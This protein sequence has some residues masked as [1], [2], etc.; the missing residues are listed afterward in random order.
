[1]TKH[2]GV[3]VTASVRLWQEKNSVHFQVQ[4][5]GSG[6]DLR[7]PRP[8]SGLTNMRERIAAIGGTLAIASRAGHGTTVRG[9]VPLAPQAPAIEQDSAV[10]RLRGDRARVL[11]S[12]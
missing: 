12:R 11:R 6:F 3:G 10:R 8:G 4:D 5:D 9:R 7:D 1:M 2:A